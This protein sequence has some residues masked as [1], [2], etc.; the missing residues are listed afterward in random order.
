MKYFLSTTLFLLIYL[1]ATFAQVQDNFSD[2]DFI[3]NPTWIGTSS[4]FQV[5]AAQELQSNGAA[6]TDTI[7]LSTPN[8]LISNIEWKLKVRLAFAPS[9]SN[10]I[11][12]YLVSDNADLTAALNGYFIQIGENGANDALKLYRQDAGLAPILL[13]TGTLGT[14]ASN[15][16]VSLKITRDNAGLWTVFADFAGGTNYVQDISF[17]DNTYTS[18]SHFGLWIK[19]TS[20]NNTKHYFDDIYVDVPFVDITPPSILAADPISSTELDVLFNEGVDLP[21]SQTLVNY[22][23]NNGMGTPSSAS[24]DNANTSLVH[25][26]YATSF[27]TGLHTL[28]VNNVKDL[29]NNAITT[30]QTINFSYL[31]TGT[32]AW[33]DVIINEIMADPTPL[34]HLQDAEYVELYNKG[35]QAFDLT[36]WQIKKNTTIATLGSFILLPNEYVIVTAPSKTSLFTGNVIGATSWAVPYFLDNN[37]TNIELLSDVGTSID[38]VHYDISWYKDA[39]K[40]NGGWS[41]ELVNPNPA[42]CIATG[43]NWIAAA[44]TIGGTPGLQNSVFNATPDAT[45]PLLA[46]LT[47]LTSTTVQICFNETMDATSLGVLANY[48]NSVNGNATVVQVQPDNQCVIATFS[49]PFQAGVLYEIRIQNVKDC[50]GNMIVTVKDTIFISPLPQYKDVIINEIMS[51]PSPV[52]GLPNAEYVELYNRGTQA[53]SLYNWTISDGVGKGKI[54]SFTLQPQSYVLLTSTTNISLFGTLSNVVS[55]TSF[56]SLNNAGDKLGLRSVENVLLD[57]VEYSIDWYENTGKENGGWS[58]EL[59]N[60]NSPCSSAA[61]WSP[62]NAA[63]GGTPGL[64]NSVYSSVPDQTPPTIV[65]AQIMGN[66]SIQVCFSESMD[67]NT[68]N[69]LANFSLNNGL[70]IASVTPIAPNNQCAYLKLSS[71][72]VAGVLYTLTIANVKD[73]SGNLIPANLTTNVVKGLTPQNFEVVINEIFADPTPTQ[74]LPEVEYIEIYNRTNKVLDISNW[75]IGDNSSTVAEWDNMIILPNQYITICHKDNVAQF[76]QYGAVIG[77]AAF[78]SFTNDKDSVYLLDNF[79]FQ[80]D[81]VFYFD[82]WYRDDIKKQGG[83]SLEKIDVDFV[84]CN[85]ALNWQGSN[86]TIGGTPSAENSVVGIFTDTEQ[87]YIKGL[88]I[89]S[90]TEVKLFFNEQMDQNALGQTANYNI[91]NGQG[92]PNFVAAAYNEAILILPTP[93]QSQILYELKVTNLTDCAGNIL[94]DTLYLGF[95]DTMQVGDILMN[96]VLF[97]P[98]TGGA[99]FIEIIN[100]SDK[101]LDLSQLSLGE[102]EGDSVYNTIQV[103]ENAALILPNETICLTTDEAFQKNTYSPPSAAKFYQMPAFPSYDDTKGGIILMTGTDTLDRLDYDKVD[104]HLPVFKEGLSWERS[105]IYLPVNCEY[106]WHAAAKIANYATPGYTNTNVGQEA[107]FKAGDV[108]INEV[109]FNPVT[110]GSD[111]VEIYNNSGKNLNLSNFLVAKIAKGETQISDLYHIFGDRDSLKAGELLCISEN[112]KSQKNQYMPPN[113]AQLMETDNFP[114]YDDTEG[115]VIIMTRNDLTLDRFHYFDDYQY[116]SLS[117]KNGVALERISLTSPTSQVTN[118]HSAA[119]TVRYGTPGYENSQRVEL[120][121]GD[122][123]VTL[124]YD[125][126]TPNGDGD[127]DVLPINYKFNFMGANARINIY[128]ANGNLVKHLALNQLLGTEGGTIFWDGMT[129]KNQKA[130]I[131]MYVIVFEVQHEDTGKKETFK[132]VC[133]VGDKF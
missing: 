89:I 72:I 45:A 124:E 2:G 15:P 74:G 129:D 25:L 31:Q 106:T 85:N 41:L 83:F 60:P 122:Q 20:T 97:N 19:H 27:P 123:S 75:K 9:I 121:G 38:S 65:S 21:T 17:T 1:Q 33:K 59:K 98:Y 43:D 66:D 53:V 114:T 57:S 125:V 47:Q 110:G 108:L 86:A 69:T 61:N 77:T 23:V 68:I 103:A 26:T 62:A 63:L 95:P 46:D 116:P 100:V 32:A 112:V 67:E 37:G 34:V 107:C 40:D 88:Q 84:N 42:A 18:T 56:P 131:G 50:S 24:R 109:L 29:N 111:Y 117:D 96:E 48:N 54:G 94:N 102:V 76:A 6:A 58:L 87:P 113:D 91:S 81:Y 14:V 11:R 105:P 13:A 49:A 82:T 7:Y 126:F 128:D 55:V 120:A 5:N 101:V 22:S 44:D 80:Q 64:Q 35:T 119:S 92:N 16:N 52:V 127:T 132:K 4:L 39:V 78:P 115:E 133:V 30:P 79:G 118:W 36:G 8:T 12:I 51:I 3:T 10:F 28:S 73:C 104:Y 90:N 70:T 130:L 71:P 93:I 99:D